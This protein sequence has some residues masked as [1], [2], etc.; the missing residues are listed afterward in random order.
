M[1]TIKVYRRTI[2]K[3]MGFRKY[4]FKAIDEFSITYGKDLIGGVEFDNDKLRVPFKKV[5]E[6]RSKKALIIYINNLGRANSDKK[7]KNIL[8]SL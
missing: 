1:K 2:Q 6:T 3:W 5:L 7:I 8:I 4:H